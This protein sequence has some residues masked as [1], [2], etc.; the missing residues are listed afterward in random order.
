MGAAHH[1]GKR[2]NHE[3]ISI[4]PTARIRILIS[5]TKSQ[6]TKTAM[7]ASIAIII[8]HIPAVMT[9]IRTKK[10][11]ALIMVFTRRAEK[12]LPISNT[13]SRVSPS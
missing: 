7:P 1:V 12:N 2:N 6:N 11:T 13:F 5:G 9:E 10:P 4:T 8:E 3:K